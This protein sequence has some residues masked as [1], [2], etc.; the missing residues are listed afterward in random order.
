VE[1][2]LKSDLPITPVLARQLERFTGAPARYWERLWRLHD[3][4]R[5]DAEDTVVIKLP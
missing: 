3:D 2:L 4:Y 1:R 5:T